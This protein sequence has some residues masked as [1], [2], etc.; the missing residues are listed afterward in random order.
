MVGFSLESVQQRAGTL[1]YRARRFSRLYLR[2]SDVLEGVAN[3]CLLIIAL[4]TLSAAPVIG[5]LFGMVYVF[6]TGWRYVLTL[7]RRRVRDATE[8]KTVGQLL[9]WFYDQMF[10]RTPGRRL[11]L[12]AIDPLDP[13]YI[14][15]RVRYAPGHAD[16]NAER[17]SR[18]RYRRGEGFTGRAWDKPGELMYELLP[19]FPNRTEF[20]RYYVEQLRMAPETVERISDYMVAVRGIYSY[21]FRDHEG[22]LLGI[23]SIDVQGPPDNTE[24]LPLNEVERML[25]ALGGVLEA[26]SYERRS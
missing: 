3:L 18:A 24:G 12:F 23:V 11:T 8:R 14:I 21:G 6:A 26:F 9:N 22:H 13:Q 25:K 19:A 15:P 7:R 10:G 4:N 1:W 16:H 17:G 2:F 5:L 20:T